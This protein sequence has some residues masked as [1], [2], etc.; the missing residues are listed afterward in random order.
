MRI[1]NVSYSLSSKDT[2][3][4]DA[5]GRPEYAPCRMATISAAPTYSSDPNDENKKFW[6]ASPGG[7]FEI[8]CVN[9]AAVAALELGKDYY[10]DI[11]PVPAK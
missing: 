9:D 10:F 11:H 4:K 3:R 5:N 2:G 8:N 1:Q 6:D 7:K